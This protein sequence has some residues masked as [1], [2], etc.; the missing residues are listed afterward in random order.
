M[1]SHSFECKGLELASSQ[2]HRGDLLHSRAAH[3]SQGG[4]PAEYSIE[5]EAWVQGGRP[6]PLGSR[7]GCPS[8]G[9]KRRGEQ[10][11]ASCQPA[12]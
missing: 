8:D 11:A 2:S 3:C 6:K 1:L 7:A 9:F 10:R 4:C 5:G 12:V